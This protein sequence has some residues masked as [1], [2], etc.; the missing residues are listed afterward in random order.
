LLGKASSA[1]C[2][3]PSKALAQTALAQRKLVRRNG[4]VAKAMGF[5]NSMKKLV[6]G[7]GM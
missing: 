5:S 3:K 7:Q 4:F 6:G 2:A 1:A